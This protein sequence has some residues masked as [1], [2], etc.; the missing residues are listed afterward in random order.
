MLHFLHVI[1]VCNLPQL[2]Q[3]TVLANNKA[4]VFWVSKIAGLR[5][6]YLAYFQIRQI[7][8]AKNKY[9]PWH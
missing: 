4:G 9:I 7:A 8:A 6:A 2:Y 1:F 5:A 3:D